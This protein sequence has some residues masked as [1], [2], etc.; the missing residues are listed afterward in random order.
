MRSSLDSK[1]RRECDVMMGGV[2]A[3]IGS[4]VRRSAADPTWRFLALF[5]V[6]L[7]AVGL[8]LPKITSAFPDVTRLMVKATA[9]IEY[10]LLALFTEQASLSDTVVH[11]GPFGV[12][13]ISEC[14]G[15]FEMAI[16]T[17]CVLAFPTSWR[18]KGIGLLFGVP[19]IYAFNVL[20][21]LCLL[22]V[23]RYANS[24]FDF[25]HLYFWQGTLIL[26]ITTVW[27]LWIYLVVRDE[28]GASVPG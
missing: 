19:A 15:L 4:W 13:I 2:T 24:S 25:F 14:T 17:A 6:Y 11:L 12:Q 9:A 5:A 18:K 7:A 28:T 8:L 23:G 22:L 27:M 26:M 21:I 1:T 20:R 3:A 16:Y 10:A